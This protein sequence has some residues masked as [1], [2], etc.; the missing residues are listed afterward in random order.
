MLSCAHHCVVWLSQYL[1]INVCM[2]KHRFYTSGYMGFKNMIWRNRSAV[3]NGNDI[4]VWYTTPR[5]SWFKDGNCSTK[6]FNFDNI[7]PRWW[8]ARCPTHCCSFSSLKICIT[9]R[10]LVGMVGVNLPTC[11][12]QNTP[13]FKSTHC[14]VKAI[15]IT[16]LSHV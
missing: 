8:C 7:P 1:S 10:M 2:W 15:A 3:L 16:C 13:V 14:D 6:T 5:I 9:P 12:C 4:Q 11:V